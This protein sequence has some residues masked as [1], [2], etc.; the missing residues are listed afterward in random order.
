MY[1]LNKIMVIMHKNINNVVI[2][3]EQLLK[4][5]QIVGMENKSG[6]AKTE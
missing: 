2:C 6:A 3:Y 1:N 5:I 4:T